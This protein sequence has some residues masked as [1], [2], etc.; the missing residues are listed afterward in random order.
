VIGILFGFMA[1]RRPSAGCSPAMTRG[2][3]PGRPAARRG[4]GP[5]TGRQAG[6]GAPVRSGTETA[7][8]AGLLPDRSLARQNPAGVPAH[9]GR[10]AR[11]GVPG[12]RGG[13]SA[14]SSR[15]HRAAALPRSLSWR[16]RGHDAAQSSATPRRHT[17]PLR[18]LAPR[19]L[20][21]NSTEKLTRVRHGASDVGFEGVER[22]GTADSSRR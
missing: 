15:G 2:H 17:N 19:H 6:S 12:G 22:V 21:A 10:A 14:G 20:L 16:Q 18:Q 7:A 8:N 3:G 13:R 4:T 5:A 1:V 11:P 9:P